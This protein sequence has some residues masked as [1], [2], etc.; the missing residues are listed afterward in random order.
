MP[1]EKSELGY[2]PYVSEHKVADSLYKSFTQ[3]TDFSSPTNSLWQFLYSAWGVSF[4]RVATLAGDSVAFPKLKD[5]FKKPEMCSAL[6]IARG[7]QQFIQHSD[8]TDPKKYTATL[9]TILHSHIQSN[10]ING[11]ERI[12]IGSPCFP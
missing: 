10:V 2:D 3:L 6:E 8:L 12:Q 7:L 9:Q 1:V 11:T 5:F 4:A